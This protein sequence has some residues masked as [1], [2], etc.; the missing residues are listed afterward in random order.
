MERKV[1]PSAL[2][3]MAEC[4]AVG[5]QERRRIEQTYHPGNER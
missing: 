5:G 4:G 2:T 3:L 1:Y